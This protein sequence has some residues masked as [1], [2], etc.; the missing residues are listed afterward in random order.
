[1]HEH[2]FAYIAADQRGWMAHSTCVYPDCH[3]IRLYKDGDVEVPS[4]EAVDSWLSYL[5]DEAP[6]KSVAE[7]VEIALTI[8]Y[9]IDHYNN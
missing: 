1:M 9:N 4:R 7:R 2:T 8:D 5:A 6:E 3:E